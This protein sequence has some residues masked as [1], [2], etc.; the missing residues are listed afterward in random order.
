MAASMLS[1]RS[2]WSLCSLPSSWIRGAR[3]GT[4]ATPRQQ[5][6]AAP[7]GRPLASGH[8]PRW[9]APMHQQRLPT[10]G[11]GTTSSVTGQGP[12][13][14]RAGTAPWDVRAA[15]RRRRP[16]LAAM[17]LMETLM[18]NHLRYP[19]SRLPPAGEFPAR[20]RPLIR[21]CA[22]RAEP[23]GPPLSVLLP[24]QPPRRRLT[25]SRR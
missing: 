21:S 2:R 22:P 15:P 5:F 1:R 16:G 11:K 7:R 18:T 24:G 3:P 23:I 20:R 8:R 13:G 14:Q 12:V 19:T 10:V 6:A 17:S 25:R 4:A 9:P